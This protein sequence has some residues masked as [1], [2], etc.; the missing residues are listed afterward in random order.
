[1]RLGSA[2]M[3]TRGLLEADFVRIAGLIDR[4]LMNHENESVLESTRKEINTWMRDFPL[5][6]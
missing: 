5:Y 4:V 3:T 1:M 6:P 2:A